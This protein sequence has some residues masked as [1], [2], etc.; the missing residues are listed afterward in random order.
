MHLATNMILKII[1]KICIFLSI[2]MIS[3]CSTISSNIHAKGKIIIT[4]QTPQTLNANLEADE[5][6]IPHDVTV[7]SAKANTIHITPHSKK[8]DI[9]QL[10]EGDGV[11]RIID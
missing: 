2:F 7:K 4:T 8:M 10:D 6:Y 3:N 9:I 5:I 1:I 11:A